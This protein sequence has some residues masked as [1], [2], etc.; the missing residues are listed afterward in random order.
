MRVKFIAIML[1]VSSFCSTVFA[2]SVERS[3]YWLELCKSETNAYCLGYVLGI[4]DTI[5]M[6]NLTAISNVGVG[7]TKNEEQAVKAYA[8]ASQRV[9]DG[10][11]PNE[12]TIGQKLRIWMDYLRRTPK[13]HHLLPIVT[14]STA[15]LQAF[16]CKQ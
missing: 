6:Y 11:S 16:P 12:V 7:M 14:Y 4:R 1:F 9:I 8:T 3:D 15:L 5:H 2:Q 10:C 13:D